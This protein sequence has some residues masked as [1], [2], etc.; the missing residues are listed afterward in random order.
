PA[1]GYRTPRPE[2]S[3][4]IEPHQLAPLDG[5]YVLKVAQP[6]NELV[7]LDRL[8]LV[9]LDHS[10]DVH[11]YADERFVSSGPWA[12][13]ELLAFRERIFPQAARDHRG[14]D[15]LPRVLAWDRDTVN[16]FTRRSWLGFAEEHGIELDFGDRLARFRP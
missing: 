6:M 10:A 16:D 15:V 13:Q 9:A 4:K 14:R 3:V 8:Q 5:H 1:G 12:S 11:V 2:E 7:Y